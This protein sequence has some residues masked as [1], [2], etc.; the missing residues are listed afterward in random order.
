MIRN[1]HSSRCSA[2][3]VLANRTPCGCDVNASGCTYCA[4]A[5][6]VCGDLGDGGLVLLLDLAVLLLDLAVVVGIAHCDENV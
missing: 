2:T 4:S 6:G 1:A 3:H 5:G